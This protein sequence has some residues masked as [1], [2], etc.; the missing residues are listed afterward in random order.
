MTEKCTNQCVYIGLVQKLADLSVCHSR[1]IRQSC[2]L[3]CQH[4]VIVGATVSTD[5]TVVTSWCA[6]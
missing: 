4:H 6:I 3:K 1:C 2:L 5:Q